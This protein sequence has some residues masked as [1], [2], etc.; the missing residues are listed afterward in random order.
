MLQAALRSARH[1]LQQ[2]VN[3]MMLTDVIQPVSVI[4][5]TN[6]CKCTDSS[7][8]EMMQVLCDVRPV[9]LLD[10]LETNL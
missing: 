9:S 7:M 5:Y 6:R 2:T 4:N 10:F 1:E 3:A 8:S